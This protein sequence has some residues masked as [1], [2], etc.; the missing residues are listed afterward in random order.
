MECTDW[1]ALAPDVGTRALSPRLGLACGRRRSPRHRRRGSAWA[2]FAAGMLSTTRRWILASGQTRT[3]RA[4]RASDES[5]IDGDRLRLGDHRPC[6]LGLAEVEVHHARRLDGPDGEHR[7]R[8]VEARRSAR[9]PAAP[10]V[11]AASSRYSPPNEE[12]AIAAAPTSW[13]MVTELVTTVRPLRRA[14]SS[15]NT[16]VVVPVSTKSVSPG[17][18]RAAA[19]RPPPASR[20]DAR[21]GGSGRR[22]HPPSRAGWRRRGI[23]G[24]APLRAS[25]ARS[26]RTVSGEAASSAARDST[27]TALPL[28]QQ[29]DNAVTPLPRAAPSRPPIDPFGQTS[30]TVRSPPV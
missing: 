19:R 17:P 26:R 24:S 16:T 2:R 1:R 10:S 23:C 30:L 9:R 7:M 4:G 8:G 6:E 15:A 5:A 12:G 13:A 11:C 28:A 14:N 29:V 18:N 22:P 3:D 25:A 27:L 21:S 20:A